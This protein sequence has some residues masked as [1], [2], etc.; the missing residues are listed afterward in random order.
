VPGEP[1]IT[2]K[3]GVSGSRGKGGEIETV[4]LGVR[5][6]PGGQLLEAVGVSIGN[7]SGSGARRHENLD[8][9]RD[10]ERLAI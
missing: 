8:Q 4:A 5:A 9:K 7:R 6:K 3:A 2:A 10:K 1:E